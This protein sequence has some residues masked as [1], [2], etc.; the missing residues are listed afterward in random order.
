MNCSDH[1]KRKTE[2]NRR[3]LER[4]R[5]VFRKRLLQRVF[6]VYL[7]VGS[8]PFSLST[9]KRATG[10]ISPKDCVVSECRA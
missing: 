1:I 8:H 5:G 9:E 10:H 2:N 7:G 4:R 6:R 3:D